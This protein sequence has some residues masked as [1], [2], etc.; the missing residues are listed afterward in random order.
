MLCTTL[1]HKKMLWFTP[2]TVTKE[3]VVRIPR[4]VLWSNRS[5]PPKTRRV[6]IKLCA[7]GLGNMAKQVL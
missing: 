6:Q 3:A 5:L 2:W 1:A 4:R 7:S